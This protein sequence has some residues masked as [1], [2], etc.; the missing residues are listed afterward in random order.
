MKVKSVEV[1]DRVTADPGD[2]IESAIKLQPG[3]KC[4]NANEISA[5]LARRYSGLFQIQEDLRMA[6]DYLWR[7]VAV[8]EP[9][10]RSALFVSAVIAYGRCFNEAEARGTKLDAKSPW[11]T[12]AGNE[13]RL[14]HELMHLRDQAFA[15]SGNNNYETSVVSVI[16]DERDLSKVQIHCRKL[17]VESASNENVPIIVTHFET[18]IARVEEKAKKAAYRL[19]KVL[20]DRLIP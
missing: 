11:I 7:M 2:R 5:P 8:S 14:H 10:V 3:M 12:V 4:V 13:K 19:N 20:L 1:G 18:L 16:Y 17:I 15:H 6:R 9:E